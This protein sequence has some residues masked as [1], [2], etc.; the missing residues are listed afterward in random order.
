MKILKTMQKIPGGVLIVPLVLGLLINSFFPHAL[1]IGSFTTAL[2]KNATQPLLALFILCAGSQ[3]DIH[4]AG[5]SLSKGFALTV[6]K[7]L[8]GA[9]IGLFIGKVY[10]H[11]GILGISILAIIPAMTN[12]NSSLFAALASQTGDDTDVGAVSVIALN[13]GPLFT[14]I[15]LGSAGLASISIASFVAVLVPIIVGFILGNID[16]DWREYL[17][18]GKMLIPFLGFSI[19]GSLD[20]KTIQAAGFSGILLGVSTLLLTG[21]GGYLI[22]GIFKGSNRAVGAAIGTTAGIAAATPAAIAAIDSSMNPF[23]KVATVQVSASIIVT[24]LL[25]PVLVAVLNNLGKKKN[26]AEPELAEESAK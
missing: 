23:V 9:V 14:M 6:C 26:A 5:I 18:H 8:I 20:I 19:G 11:A 24:A 12:S 15:I 10:G 25:C 22:Y 4:K 2:F 16:P 1:G 13:N 7:I 17:K 3:I 21:L